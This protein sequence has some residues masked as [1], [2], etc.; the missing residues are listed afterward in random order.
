MTFTK[1]VAMATNYKHGECRKVYMIL[2]HQVAGSIPAG[3][4]TMI[5]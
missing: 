4:S 2:T 3:I 1:L 5:P